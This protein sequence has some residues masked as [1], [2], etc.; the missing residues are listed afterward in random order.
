ML[1]KGAFLECQILGVGLEFPSVNTSTEAM[2]NMPPHPH[3]HMGGGR[4]GLN[5]WGADVTGRVGGLAGESIPGLW[6]MKP[7]VLHRVLLFGL[8]LVQGQV[9]DHF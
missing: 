5:T 4:T 8:S 1:R 7:L 3:F 2:R 6:A 9:C